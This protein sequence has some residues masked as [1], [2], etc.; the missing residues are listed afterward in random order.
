M[1]FSE[2]VGSD[3]AF[4]ARRSAGRFG[5]D[6]ICWKTW[7][8]CSFRWALV[9]WRPGFGTLRCFGIDIVCWEIWNWCSFSYSISCW[10]IWNWHSLLEDLELKKSAVILRSL[11][12]VLELMPAERF[13]IVI[14]CWTVWFADRFGIEL[15]LLNDRLRVWEL[16]QLCSVVCWKIAN[17]VLTIDGLLK[18]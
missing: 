1:Q 13:G 6:T 17:I 2:R 5:I 15:G 11:L 4:A 14:V 7:N 10:W 18:K 16:I 8:W 3:T 9:N 12:E